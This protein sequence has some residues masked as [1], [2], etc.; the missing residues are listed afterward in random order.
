M[1]KRIK[2][3]IFILQHYIFEELEKTPDV[4]VAAT[5]RYVD[6]SQET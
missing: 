4:A 1:K 3:Q 6:K 2:K 5:D